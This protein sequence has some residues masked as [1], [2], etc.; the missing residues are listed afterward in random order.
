[1]EKLFITPPKKPV[2]QL[3]VIPV[4][5]KHM[6]PSVEHHIMCKAKPKSNDMV[7]N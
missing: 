3:A 2:G 4:I 7:H 1:M 6:W 5:D